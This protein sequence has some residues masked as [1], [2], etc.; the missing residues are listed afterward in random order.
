MSTDRVKTETAD[1]TVSDPHGRKC[2]P[3]GRSQSGALPR[4]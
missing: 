1:L 3:D 2:A 4:L